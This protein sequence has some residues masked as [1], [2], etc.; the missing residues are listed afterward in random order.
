M[1]SLPHPPFH[2]NHAPAALSVEMYS[3]LLPRMK[4]SPYLFF[5]W[6]LTY[7]CGEE[8][9]KGRV[10]WVGDSQHQKTRA[11]LSLSPTRTSVCSMAMF[12]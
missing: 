3:T 10:V 12:M 6:P 7:S 1:L 2:P 11:Q 5:S 9:G 8:R 4:A